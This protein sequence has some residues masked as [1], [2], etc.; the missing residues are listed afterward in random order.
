MS[1]M[2]SYYYY[3]NNILLI[4]YSESIY[5]KHGIRYGDYDTYL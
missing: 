4:D 3:I 1:F 5:D 2:R